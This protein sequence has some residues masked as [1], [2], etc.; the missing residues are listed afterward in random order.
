MAFPSSSEYAVI[1]SGIHR[2]STAYH[3]ARDSKAVNRGGGQDINLI[4]NAAIGARASQSFCG[5]LNLN[6]QP[7]VCEII[8]H[9]ACVWESEVQARSYYTVGSPQKVPDRMRDDAPAIGEQLRG[10]DYD[11]VFVTEGEK[12]SRECTTN[13]LGDRWVRGFPSE[14]HKKWGCY[15]HNTA[16]FN[17]PGD[18]VEADGVRRISGVD[19]GGFQSVNG[20]DRA[21]TENASDLRKTNDEAFTPV[22]DVDTGAPLIFDINGSINSEEMWSIYHKPDFNFGVVQGGGGPIKIRTRRDRVNVDPHGPQSADWVV[23]TGAFNP[24]NFPLIN[25]YGENCDMIVDS[26]NG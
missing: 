6:V 4:A 25:V 22:E 10:T 7:V 16:R 17:D 23:G 19:V 14:L 21:I 3:L 24:G 12:V 2:L 18:K 15:G 20:S 26:D 8:T 1:G 5:V 11:S 13:K 9:R